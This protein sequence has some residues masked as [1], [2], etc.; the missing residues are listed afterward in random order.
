MHMHVSPGGQ[1]QPLTPSSTGWST[2]WSATWLATSSTGWSATS[3]VHCMTWHPSA[4]FLR[5]ASQDASSDPCSVGQQS[6]VTCGTYD[7]MTKCRNVVWVAS[8]S[9]RFKR[10]TAGPCARRSSAV[11]VRPGRALCS[12]CHHLHRSCPRRKWVPPQRRT[13]GNCTKDQPDQVPR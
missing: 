8:P 5:G 9:H 12:T 6:R 7:S 10:G 2:G 11:A 13:K 1:L 4:L 3:T